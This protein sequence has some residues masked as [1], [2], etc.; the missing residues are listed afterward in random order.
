MSKCQAGEFCGKYFKE[1]TNFHVF[2]YSRALQN[3]EN[4][5]LSYPP[6]KSSITVMHILTCHARTQPVHPVRC[7]ELQV[8]ESLRKSDWN[9]RTFIIK[10]NRSLGVGVFIIGSDIFN[11]RQPQ[12]FWPQRWKESRSWQVEVNQ[13]ARTNPRNP[14]CVAHAAL[15]I[16]MHPILMCGCLVPSDCGICVVSVFSFTVT[17]KYIK[18][19]WKFS[20][21]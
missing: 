2:K 1:Q 6:N 5:L 19:F 3:K 14:C 8:R 16:H 4:F 15:L 21:F 13:G 20:I 18:Y 17:R 10:P 11:G 7:L 12:A 9:T